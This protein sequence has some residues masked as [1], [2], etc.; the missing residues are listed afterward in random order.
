VRLCELDAKELNVIDAVVLQDFLNPSTD[1]V[2]IGDVGDFVI[3]PFERLEDTLEPF[4]AEIGVRYR[5]GS[6][7][8]PIGLPPLPPPPPSPSSSVL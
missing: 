7:P 6:A 3:V 5:F 4:G 8:S 2:L 1:L